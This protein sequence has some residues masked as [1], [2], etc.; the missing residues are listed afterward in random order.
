MG[1]IRSHAEIGSPRAPGL[2]FA[3]YPSI[4]PA[5]SRRLM[6]SATLGAERPTRRAIIQ[7][8]TCDSDGRIDH[9]VDREGVESSLPLHDVRKGEPYLIGVF[10]IGA[11]QEIL[12]DM[13]NLFGDTDAVNL[14][15]HPDGSY[16]LVQ[17][18]RGDTVD[19]LLRYVHFDAEELLAA[20][21]DKI[22]D[23]DLSHDLR[24][25]YLIELEEGL[26]G[27]TYLEE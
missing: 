18:Q 20:Y 19:E 16:S 17:P 2:I 9:Y 15:L 12:G 24:K 14:E 4:T 8:L 21:R 26:R 3:E 11:Y 27:Y 1:L 22:N 23:T 5:S 10:L 7:D 25:A 6:R 13:H